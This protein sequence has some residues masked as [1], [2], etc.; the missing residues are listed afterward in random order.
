VYNNKKVT[1]LGR[2]THMTHLYIIRHGEAMSAIKGF[3]GDGGLSPLGILQAKR[4]R[5]RLAATREINPDVLIASTLPR[6]H[7]TAQ[8]IAP[9]LGVSLQL[10]DNIQELRPGAAEGMPVE[11]FREEFGEPDYEVDPYRPIAPGGENWGEFML[12]VGTALDH[13]IRKY[14]GKTI[15]LVC[16]GGII[17]GS[18]LYFFKISSW[19]FPPARF[20]TRNTSITHWQQILSEKDEWHWHLIRY[21]DAFH[22][23]DIGTPARIPWEQIRPNPASDRDRP[24]VPLETES[25]TAREQPGDATTPS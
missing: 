24:S 2:T 13:I 5:D 16:H 17:D 4:L 25:F 8:I 9:A 23:H 10:D 1:L 22:L 19:T 11:M 12:R 21:N 18:F 15:V 14:A 7:Q 3:V 20:Y 6:A